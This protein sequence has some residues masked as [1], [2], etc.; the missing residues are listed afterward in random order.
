MPYY[1]PILRNPLLNA[2]FNCPTPQ[3][4]PLKKVFSQIG[5]RKFV[6]VAPAAEILNEY[7]DLESG[8][9]VQDLCYS[10][11]F[12]ADHILMLDFREEMS[13]EEYRTLSGKTVAVRN[14]QSFITTGDGFD[15][16]RRCR[17][18]ETELLTNFNEYLQ[19]SATYPVLHVDFPFTGRL[20][21][22]DE[23]QLLRVVGP[24]AEDRQGNALESDGG[25]T[26]SGHDASLE[27]MLRIHPTHAAR[28]S[29]IF[30][31][32]REVLAKSRYTATA[33]AS[34]FTETCE[35][36]ID[37]IGQD[38]A[39]Q[40]LP[41][42]QSHVHEYAELTL[43]DFF[44]AQLTNSMKGQ[45]IETLSDYKV[46]RNISISQ[47]PTFLFPSNRS[48]FDL[49]YVTQ[50][51]KNLQEAVECF[52]KLS[53]T[54][55]HSAKAKVIVESLQTI[56][57]SISV[58]GKVI[59]IDADTLVSLLV[60]TVCRAEVRDLKSHLFYLQEF[61]KNSSQVTFGILAY[62]MST[63]EAV[64]SYF[65]NSKKLHMLEKNCSVN[66]DFWTW[67][68]TPQLEYDMNSFP[69]FEKLL[70]IRTSSGHS[71]LAFCLQNRNHELFEHLA[72]NYEKYFPL[73]DLL[74]DETVEGS[75]LLI[76]ML[77]SGCYKLAETFVSML[78]HSCTREELGIFLN[79]PDRYQR[80]SGHY[81]M[82]APKLISKIGILL[83][84]EKQD[85]NGHTPL[86]AVIRA[87][88]HP[89]YDLMISEAYQSAK[90]WCKAQNRQFRISKHA[91][92]K[93]NTLLHV[94]R[95]NC[96]V[97]LNDPFVR[98]NATNKKGLTPL[99]VYAK[100]NRLDNVKFIV[101]DNRLIIDKY[102]EGTY[103]TCFDYFKNPTILK[104]LGKLPSK[105]ASFGINSI[106]ARSIKFESDD[107]VMWMTF[108]SKSNHTSAVVIKRPLT[109]IQNYMLLFLKANPTTFVPIKDLVEELREL[110][111]M[112]IIS[113]N[114]IETQDF[115]K[116]A[117][118][119]LSVITQDN[120]FADAFHNSNLNLDLK[121][122]NDKKL[123]SSDFKGTIEP[124]EMT[125]IQKI[126]KY[127]RAE[128]VAFKEGA[129][130]LKK[131][132]IFGDLK[133]SDLNKSHKQFISR[134]NTYFCSND[135]VSGTI[136][137]LDSL[138]HRTAFGSFV[139]NVS[140]F[141]NCAEILSRNIEKVLTGDIS[142]WWQTYGE[143]AALRH[144]YNKN[145][146]GSI[147]PNVTANP[148]LFGSYIETKRSKL[149]QSISTKI[150][151]C[152]SIL[153]KLG[154][155]IRR[156]N[157][158]LAVEVNKF[159]NFKND[160]WKSVTIE[161]HAELNIKVLRDQLVCLE[162]LLHDYKDKFDIDRVNNLHI[163]T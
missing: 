119:V 114:R 98:V 99:M 80:T 118:I 8:L 6:L 116:K 10:A 143:L 29:G 17:I 72:T 89:D 65:D 130:V 136:P 50:V 110:S 121:T 36:V 25:M 46:L 14:Q 134:A 21:R 163:G 138:L 157:E 63:L 155:S 140:F 48:K 97:L 161:E 90:S 9:L 52:K 94:I 56:S 19:A 2:V 151:H 153:V 145:F 5:K 53:L 26:T 159:I 11:D 15:T 44:W 64:L 122:G 128:L 35:K 152:S 95:S 78:C 96:L 149:E 111:K 62:G 82:H 13:S 7:E 91:D 79:H 81:I 40:K 32:Q 16:R 4:S 74:R 142:K 66:R 24:L 92:K 150:K 30:K 148:G 75:N 55:S 68:S 27:Q 69:A 67:L 124:E 115:L 125:S 73:E 37:I 120:D 38:E 22:R 60:V 59:P 42:L 84:W 20:A 43:Y 12:V 160:F 54:N 45:E 104:E 31:A 18:L 58:N 39:F 34:H 71:I 123:H 41:N 33:L 126:L 85:C 28:L 49:R 129:L 100:Y 3:N 154:L 76:Q 77:D 86:F 101:Q 133:S 57:R 103:L 70:K 132:A 107:W 131:L 127:Y 93:G 1:L 61:A 144:E 87:Y 88:D 139:G 51:E 162:E 158:H 156:E 117:S 146:P 112:K 113:I 108:M 83:H 141:Q 135:A 102:Q 47:V 23:W 105:F 147:R 109:F 106:C 137:D